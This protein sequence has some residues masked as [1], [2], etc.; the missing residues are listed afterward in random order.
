MIGGIAGEVARILNPE[1]EICRDDRFIRVLQ[2]SLENFDRLVQL[3]RWCHQIGTT[4]FKMLVDIVT[5]L[6]K[7]TLLRQLIAVEMEQA[8]IA[9]LLVQIKRGLEIAQANQDRL[10][11]F[12]DGA[13]AP[14]LMVDVLIN[15]VHAEM[16]MVERTL[17][18]AANAVERMRNG[19]KR[20]VTKAWFFGALAVVAAV[21]FPPAAIPLMTATSVCGLAA[22]KSIADVDDNVAALEILLDRDNARSGHIRR[23][24]RD[25]EL[26][27]ERLEAE[28]NRRDVARETALLRN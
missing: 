18:I 15:R 26:V 6:I 13:E 3:G 23:Q 19:R 27:L 17:Q 2:L 22:Y 5:W 25:L 28:N 4:C 9:P 12:A 14:N 20:A 21:V 24:D 10:F 11:A 1:N 7:T 16:E 8:R